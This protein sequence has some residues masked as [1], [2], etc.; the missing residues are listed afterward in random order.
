MKNKNFVKKLCLCSLYAVILF[1]QE[2]VLSFIPN[3]QFTFLIII[4]VGSVLGLKWGS[5]IV[6]I[7]VIMDNLFCGSF[8]PYVVI[9]M[10]I[11]EEITLLFGYLT[12]KS[13]LFIVIIFGVL[14]SLI[15]CYMFIPFNAIFLKVNFLSYFLADILFE[16][17]LVI[18]TILTLIWL[19]NPLKKVIFEQWSTLNN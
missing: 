8:V 7:N 14:A 15:Y 6:I 9:P 5:L 10:L 11:G 18:S 19:Y 3:V 2:Q 12:R 16:I 1:T 4:V 17:I 13:N